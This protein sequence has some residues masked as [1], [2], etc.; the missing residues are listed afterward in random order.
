MYTS[1]STKPYENLTYKTES[2][3][4]A[5]ERQGREGTPLVSIGAY[6]LMPNHFHLLVKEEFE[7]GIAKFMQRLLT[8][9]TMYFNKKHD[10]TGPLFAGVFKSR[11]VADDRYLQRVA[12]YI[13]LNPTDLKIDWKQVE[14]YPYSSL[15]DFSSD[16]ERLQKS[17][18]GKEIFQLIDQDL[19]RDNLMAS[20]K[21]YSDMIESPEVSP[22]D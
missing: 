22:R 17:I 8:G 19:M 13:H 3:A 21:E 15:A 10:R 2:L 12:S 14:S 6:C 9:Y 20:A 16:T 7:G 11:H 4:N 5:L 18:L 1:N